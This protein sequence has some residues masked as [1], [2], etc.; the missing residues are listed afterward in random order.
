MKLSLREVMAKAVDSY[1][2]HPRHEWVLSWPGQVVLASSTVHWAAEVTQVLCLSYFCYCV[3]YLCVAL[4]GALC[5]R[6][7]KVIL[8]L[9]YVLHFVFC[10]VFVI[11]FLLYSYCHSLLLFLV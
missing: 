3:M 6:E 8:C 11:L 1:S 10:H 5:K 4:V 9:C 2:T 7:K